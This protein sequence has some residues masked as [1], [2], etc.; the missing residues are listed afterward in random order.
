MK[1]TSIQT[2]RDQ[3]ISTT[4][5]I[6]FT[7][8][9]YA[10]DG[11]GPYKSPNGDWFP[12]KRYNNVLLSVTSMI[13]VMEMAER[14][15]YYGITSS[16]KTYLQNYLGYTSAQASALTSTVSN[17]NYF[18]PLLG[19]Y[20][21]DVKWGR[22]NTIL[23]FGLIY[24][25]GV[26][27][28]AVAAEPSIHSKGLFLFA[29]Y[30]LIC[31]GAGGIKP[32]VSTFGADQFDISTAKGLKDQERF[33]NA[34][35]WVINIGAFVAYGVLGQMATN[36][37]GAIPKDY[38]FFWTFTISAGAWVLAIVIF[39]LGTPRYIKL[40]PQGSGLTTFLSVFTNA[41]KR[42]PKGIMVLSSLAFSVFIA[43]FS[44]VTSFMP[45]SNAV[46]Y[47][48]YGLCV[49][50]IF[51]FLSVTM[52]NRDP[53]YI[54]K[55]SSAIV[56]MSS[57]AKKSL[58]DAY[59]FA[60]VWSPIFF[61]T[62]FWIVYKQMAGNMYA[63]ACQCD[64]IVFGDTQI[65]G[66]FLNLGD[67]IAIIVLIPFLESFGYPLIEKVK[68]SKFTPLQKM[69]WGFICALVAMILTAVIE[70]TRKNAPVY[71]QEQI[72]LSNCAPKGI[73]M[74]EYSVWYMTFPYFLIGAAEV[75]ISVPLYELCY[76][77]VPEGVRSSANAFQ[78]F[79]KSLAS[80]MS[81]VI[82][83]V[84]ASWITNDLND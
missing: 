26:I 2:P 30:G 11:K 5:H 73:Y 9:R 35:Y 6:E 82:T 77:Q 70:I 25:A 32:N 67:C 68:G 31:L 81:S 34:F 58:T 19:A 10:Y 40:A 21:A 16:L 63:I 17:I 55:A 13:L 66:T 7:D 64:L 83:L 29:L 46:N 84:C 27:L 49:L 44:A 18:T 78:L 52:L 8:E 3:D 56:D 65:N 48:N 75:L 80:A 1:S 54:T 15:C 24:V 50:F 61:A 60:R 39:L 53:T 72:Y 38:G 37:M 59:M 4:A 41:A 23:V 33:F 51:S 79:T 74:S 71:P 28:T 45:K 62:I 43:V 47:I 69:F 14:L 20:L 36:G 76:S 57:D 42:T 12:A 22:Y